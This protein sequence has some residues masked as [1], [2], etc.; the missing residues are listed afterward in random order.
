MKYDLKKISK[1]MNKNYKEMIYQKEMKR[2]IL[3]EG[4]FKDYQFYIL[5]LGIYPTA[6]IE[7]PKNSYLF[8]KGCNEI[9]K[10]GLDIYVHVGLTYANGE[11]HTDDGIKTGWFIGWNYAHYGDYL[12][13]K[14]MA[15]DGL[16]T[17]DTKWTT[18]EIFNDVCGAIEQIINFDTRKRLEMNRGVDNL[19]RIVIPKEIRKKLDIKDDDKL[20]IECKDNSIVL[21]KIND[22]NPIN[23]LEKWLN[24]WKD[25]IEN[26]ADTVDG[27]DLFEEHTLIVLD[28]V[29]VKI[30]EIKGDK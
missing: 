26:Q 17:Y 1:L 18:E 2:E 27:L 8:G 11:L 23:E 30:K 12:G 6:Y 28:D 13:Y 7:I 25:N 22:D 9:Y 15:I 5:S 10:M 14:E 4:K 20:N 29:L 24:D 19:G 3:L 21:T 16:L